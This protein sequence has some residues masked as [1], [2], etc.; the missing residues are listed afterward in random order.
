MTKKEFEE[1][2]LQPLLKEINVI[3]ATKGEAY[4]PEASDRLSNFKEVGKN[5]G[6]SPTQVWATYFTKHRIAIESFIKRGS[7]LPGDEPVEGRILDCIVYLMLLRGLVKEAKDS[8]EPIYD[9]VIKQKNTELLLQTAVELK[10]ASD[11]RVQ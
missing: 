10:E 7:E 5:I 6:I 4:A 11:A 9:D 8:N 1:Q 3:F 2:V